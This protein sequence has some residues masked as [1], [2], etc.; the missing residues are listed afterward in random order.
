MKSIENL[1]FCFTGEPRSFK[2]G[3]KSREK[4]LKS[5]YYNSLK[6]ES[7]YLFCYPGNKYNNN[8]NN[9]LNEINKFKK[10]K[11]LKQIII[12]NKKQ[13]NIST[14]ILKQKYDILKQLYQEEYDHIKSTIILT[15]T[16]WLFTKGF[17]NL[18][19][20]SI[21]F[22]KVV[23]PD[24]DSPNYDYNGIKYKAIKDQFMIIPGKL[25]KKVID[26]LSV[27]IKIS[28]ESKDRNLR[29]D[30]LSKMGISYINKYNKRNSLSP[31]NSLG[32][33]F[34][35]TQLTNYFSPVKFDYHY[36]PDMYGSCK[37]NLIRD[38]AHF[39][40]K[41]SL[42]EFILKFY[43]YSKGEFSR[44]IRAIVEKVKS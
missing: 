42:K 12:E 35:I 31:E 23:T 20:I 13:T 4:I 9:I 3:I 37:H 18:L 40:Q 30:S 17:I 36:K 33:A 27:A 43:N 6:I 34:S 10:D 15:R 7:R 38:D 25:L 44:S 2:K 41:L 11:W 8:K 21:S 26:T 32:A 16:D 39:W 28:E 19:N 1:I 14:Y 24:Q 29:K 5:S 22:E